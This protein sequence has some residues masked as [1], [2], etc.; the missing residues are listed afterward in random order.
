[1]KWSRNLR[2]LRRGIKLAT[3]IAKA[4]LD[5]PRIDPL[6][7]PAQSSRL[8]EFSGFGDNPGRLR[9]RA[10]VPPSVARRPLVVLLHGCGQDATAVR[11][12][13]RMD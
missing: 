11:R 10:Y 12:G 3:R 9:M 1:M 5:G 7:P 2:T 6:E 4:K 8:V 13:F